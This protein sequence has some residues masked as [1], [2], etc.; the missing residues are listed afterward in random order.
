MAPGGLPCRLVSGIEA[1]LRSTLI[2]G[3]IEC[4]V[5]RHVQFQTDA[6]FAICMII[7]FA[8]ALFHGGEWF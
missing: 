5:P 7:G 4:R 2:T 3:E 1:H 8:E 6:L